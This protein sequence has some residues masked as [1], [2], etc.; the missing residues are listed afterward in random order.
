MHLNISN[1]YTVEKI[2]KEQR[3]SEILLSFM[4]IK[5]KNDFKKL[6]VTL[7]GRQLAIRPLFD[8]LRDLR[9]DSGENSA[10]ELESLSRC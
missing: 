8:D 5:L 1:L 10:V 7:L 9:Q 2:K 6:I 3:N 4:L